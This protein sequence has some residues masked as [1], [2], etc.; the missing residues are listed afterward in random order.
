MV[1]TGTQ[2][3]KENMLLKLRSLV[4]ISFPLLKRGYKPPPP[5]KKTKTKNVGCMCGMHCPAVKHSSW[6]LLSVLTGMSLGVYPRA[7]EGDTCLEHTL[8]QPVLAWV[9]FV[10]PQSQFSDSDTLE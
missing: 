1:T 6:K 3:V 5:Q 10:I 8:K 7:T 9:F 4:P 2:R